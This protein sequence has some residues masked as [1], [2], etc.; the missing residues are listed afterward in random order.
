MMNR[1]TCRKFLSFLQD[2]YN[3]NNFWRNSSL[4]HYEEVFKN[5][6]RNYLENCFNQYLQ[7]H[8]PQFLPT[9]TAIQGF[10]KA[11][12]NC[13][14][15]WFLSDKS[16]Y[17][18][19]CRTDEHGLEGSYRVIWVR[20]YS[21]KKREDINLTLS[22]RCTDHQCEANKGTGRS[23]TEITRDI[24]S[25][26]SKAV[27]RYDHYCGPNCDHCKVGDRKAETEGRVRAT[28][29]GSDMWEHR[30]KHGYVEIK[31]IDGQRRYC[32]VWE[33]S[34]WATSMGR[35]QAKELNWERPEHV[36]QAERKRKRTRG[37]KNGVKSTKE[38]LSDS[39][40]DKI[41]K[42]YGW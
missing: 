20:F 18:K 28:Y 27:I 15:A 3:K 25:I 35:V 40:I 11:Q 6:P 8:M 2:H 30:I 38:H 29:Q 36:L 22:A 19:H 17:C 33:H 7:K 4:E 13:R 31:E 23:F 32:P 21:P 39:N 12:P 10:V 37:R 24:L 5:V 16:L 1:E 42:P 26:D 34:I 14:E 41:F 9:L